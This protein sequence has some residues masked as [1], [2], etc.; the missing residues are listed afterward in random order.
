M[1]KTS[2]AILGEIYDA[3]RA[4]DLDWLASYLPDDFTHTMHIPATDRWQF[5]VCQGK[6]AVIERW[7]DVIADYE[8]LL[9]DTG[10][11]LGDRTHAAVEIPLRYR[12]RGKGKVLETTKAN[13]W[14]LEDGW[15]VKL[16]EYYDVGYIQS[17]RE[18]LEVHETS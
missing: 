7:R 17:Y 3:W 16:I 10:K 11:L 1:P 15:P 18:S 8:V 6:R 9:F 12:H 5:G 14:T 2:M 4:Q 13:F